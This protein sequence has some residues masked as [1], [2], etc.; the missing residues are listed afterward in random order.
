MSV[1]SNFSSPARIQRTGNSAKDLTKREK[2]KNQRT[3]EKSSRERDNV[4]WNTYVCSV[5]VR[6]RVSIGAMN[7]KLQRRKFGKST[8]GRRRI[9][10][11]TFLKRKKHW[12]QKEGGERDVLSDD[13]RSSAKLVFFFFLFSFFLSTGGRRENLFHISKY[14]EERRMTCRMRDISLAEPGYSLRF[15]RHELHKACFE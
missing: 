15:T 8:E 9:E 13:T 4:A 6:A 14:N 3:G 5:E 10:T 12:E 7:R 11:W 2:K 1:L